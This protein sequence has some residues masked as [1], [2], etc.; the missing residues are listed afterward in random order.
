[1]FWFLFWWGFLFLFLFLFFLQAY[2]WFWLKTWI[3]FFFLSTFPRHLVPS[4][5]YPVPL[6]QLG[7]SLSH[8]L[9]DWS[10]VPKCKLSLLLA[11]HLWYC[12]LF[13]ESLVFFSFPLLLHSLTSPS[14]P[15][16]CSSSSAHINT[17]G[18][19]PAPLLFPKHHS[20]SSLLPRLSLT[21]LRFLEFVIVIWWS[22]GWKWFWHTE[23]HIF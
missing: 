3:C 13:A 12:H 16:F 19:L 22:S 4:D 21:C 7:A 14:F 8:K 20:Y 1:M 6:P 11:C 5:N 18:F 10:S 23:D 2:Q 9:S 15:G 17:L